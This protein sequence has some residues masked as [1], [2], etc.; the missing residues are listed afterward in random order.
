M[1]LL[2]Q[3]LEGVADTFGVGVAVVLLVLGVVVLVYGRRLFWA[4][5][6]L[7]GFLIGLA[8]APGL[9][10][11][12]DPNIR[13]LIIFA[14]AVLLAVVAASLQRTIIQI[15]GGIGFAMVGWSLLANATDTV[16]YGV[17]LVMFVVGLLLA[18]RLSDW[19]V[20]LASALLGAVAIINALG[21]FIDIPT[22]ISAIVFLALAGFGIYQQSRSL[23]KT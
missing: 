17:T 19:G 1:N 9:L 18:L 14:L 7:V 12:I 15:A 20:L 4:F 5:G 21:S 11:S 13:P 16:R 6:A 8:V 2:Q 22:G 3:A 10:G 23:A